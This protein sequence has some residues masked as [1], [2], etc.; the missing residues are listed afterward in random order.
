MTRA[1]S[2]LIGSHPLPDAVIN[3]LYQFVPATALGGVYVGVVDPVPV[4]FPHPDV[5]VG[6]VCH[7]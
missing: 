4:A 7:W 1:V 6:L 5:P 2:L 3:T